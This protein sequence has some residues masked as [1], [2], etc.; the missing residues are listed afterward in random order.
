M[1]KI[2]EHTLHELEAT[3]PGILES[4]LWF[5]GAALPAC[6]RCSSSDTADV[7]VGIIGRTINIAAATTKFKLIANGPKPGYF[8]NACDEFFNITI[9]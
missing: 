4:I 9:Q 5:E 1:L 7:Q 2:A 3:Y 6:P 8:C